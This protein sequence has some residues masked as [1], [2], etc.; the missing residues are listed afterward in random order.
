[1]PAP[2]FFVRE[3]SRRG[4]RKAESQ[5]YMRHG[6]AARGKSET[7]GKDPARRVTVA[8]G[9]FRCVKKNHVPRQRGAWFFLRSEKKFLTF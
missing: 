3:V 2:E 8:H 7:S 4:A 5:E 9:F 1:M 6:D